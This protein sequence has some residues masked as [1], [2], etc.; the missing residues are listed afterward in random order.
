MPRK[1]NEPER[2]CLVTRHSLSKTEMIRFVLAP[3]GQVVPDLKM[4]LPGRG[5]WVTAD[6]KVLE[7]AV[8]KHLFARGF[9]TKIGDCED[10]PDLVQRQLYM[11]ALNALSMTKKA[12]QIVTGFAKVEATIA[13]SPLLGL[14]HAADA[15]QDG[16]K[17]LAQA[18]RRRFGS[19]HTIPVIRL[20]SA[21]AMTK[22]LG[23][24]NV[25]HAA[26]TAGS[27]SQ[28]FLKQAQM[29]EAFVAGDIEFSDRGCDEPAS[30]RALRE[31]N[32]G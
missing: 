23:L 8:S 7:Q 24:G 27:A 2:Q 26:L 29:F 31:G 21:D 18:L 16:Q 30:G 15:A 22:A 1:S 12:G 25:I 17:K 9:K 6:R 5:V 32:R 20:F 28:G 4:R 10:L 11:Q 14:L 19:D 13:Q 3:D